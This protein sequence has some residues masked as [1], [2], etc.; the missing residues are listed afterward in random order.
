MKIEETRLCACCGSPFRAKRSD[1]LYCSKPCRQKMSLKAK[2]TSSTKKPR[3]LTDKDRINYFWLSSFGLWLSAALVRAGGEWTIQ[4]VSLTELLNHHAKLISFSTQCI[5]RPHI[6]HRHSLKSGGMTSP[7]NLGLLPSLVNMAQGAKSCPIGESFPHGMP[8]RDCD[9]TKDDI[10]A[11]VT[12]QR[13]AEILLLQKTFSMRP[14][15]KPDSDTRPRKLGDRSVLLFEA[16]LQG[17]PAQLFTHM[18]TAQLI[19]LVTVGITETEQ[20]E[21]IAMMNITTPPKTT[22]S[23]DFIR[24]WLEELDNNRYDWFEGYIGWKEWLIYEPDFHPDLPLP[25]RIALYKAH[26]M[27]RARLRDIRADRDSSRS[28]ARAETYRWG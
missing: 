28:D 4:G 10:L 8:L 6:S 3:R 9:R 15:K 20:Q 1:A 17:Y 16:S 2:A 27:E 19:D 14:Y 11:V 5:N 26:E 24:V 12:K 18:T 25:Q 22:K 23:Q 13:R 21:T 7:R